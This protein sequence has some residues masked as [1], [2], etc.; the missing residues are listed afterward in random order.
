VVFKELKVLKAS[1]AYKALE[2]SREPPVLLGP[3]VSG[4][5]VVELV[6]PARTDALDHE[7][8]QDRVVALD[9]K[10]LAVAVA[11]LVPE[12]A[13]VHRAAVGS[14]GSGDL[15]A[16]WANPA[17]LV[18]TASTVD[19]DLP[20]PRVV[21]VPAACVATSGTTVTPDRGVLE[22]TTVLAAP[23]AWTALERLEPQ[24]APDPAAPLVPKVQ[25][26]S[27]ASVA[28][29]ARMGRFSSPL[30]HPLPLASFL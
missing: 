7:D 2:V 28:R 20:V 12:V 4:V 17:L 3:G 9:P 21:K 6:L 16:R 8:A 30:A 27:R 14:V 19:A 26:A 13:Q 10:V 22:V 15:K 1:K 29:K 18:V 23:R 11:A 24:V 5:A 25:L